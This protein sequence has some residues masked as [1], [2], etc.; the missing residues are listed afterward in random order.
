ML[1]NPISLLQRDYTRGEGKLT[2][3]EG[4]GSLFDIAYDSI[5]P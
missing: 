5:D 4:T 2:P 3:L 1:S